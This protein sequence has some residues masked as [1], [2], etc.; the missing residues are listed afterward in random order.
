MT[1]KDTIRYAYN[2]MLQYGYDAKRFVFNSLLNGYSEDQQRFLGMITLRAHVVEKGLT[3]PAMRMNFGEENLRELITLCQEY[4][5]SGYDI[6]KTLYVNAIEAILEYEQV[7]MKNNAS[8]PDDIQFGIDN[9]KALNPKLLSSQ[10]P[11]YTKDEM[12]FHGDFAYISS[13]R[14]SVRDFVGSV[15]DDDLQK[16]LEMAGTAPSACNRQPCRIHVIERGSLFDKILEIQTGSRGFGYLADKFL[17]VTTDLS[18]YNSLYERN[19]PFVDGGI[20]VMNLLYALQYNGIAA[21][22]LNCCFGPDRDKALRE[23]LK[24]KDA[25]VAFIAIGDCPETVKV[26]KSRRISPVEYIIKH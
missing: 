11:E 10:Q 9:L 14:H 5:R 25:F 12:Y 8:L 16:A 19:C 15:N 1:F 6:A 21:C 23:L 4:G 7:H 3:M 24:T 26:A 17:V 22:T 20:F 18:A 2:G 13:H